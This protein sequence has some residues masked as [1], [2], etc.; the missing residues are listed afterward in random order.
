M[1]RANYGRRLVIA[2]RAIG[3]LVLGG[4][5]S[6]VVTSVTPVLAA[7]TGSINGRILLLGEVTQPKSVEIP[8]KYIEK[9]GAKKAVETL[10][11][12]PDHGIRNAVVTLLDVKQKVI[13]Q[14]KTLTLDQTACDFNPHVLIVP[15]GASVDILNHDGILHNIHTRS[16]KNPVLNKAQP[17]SVQKITTRF[18]EPEII[19]VTCDVHPWM[20][21]WIVVT[22]LAKAV[23]TN[24]G[25]TF[26][27]SQVPAGVHTLEV[28]HETLGTTKK[29]ILVEA[30]K[31]TN[32]TIEL[33]K[34]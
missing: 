15:V 20:L 11:V 32:I 3:K 18:S 23:A 31:E 1:A 8:A 17:G 12:S 13:S 2:P 21:A 10:V 4:W 29:K 30:G 14:K 7:P 33:R 28:W 16:S 22:D 5:L 26:S 25:G 24:D 19:R 34:K 9:C 27:L 6:C